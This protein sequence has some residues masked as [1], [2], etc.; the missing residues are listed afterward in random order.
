MRIFISGGT[1]FVGVHLADHFL[2][3]G[4]RVTAV[5]TSE[6]HPF[7]GRDSFEFISGDTVRPGPWQNAIQD[8]EAVVNLAGRTIFNYWTKKY[9]AQ[10]YDSRVITTRNIV[11]ALPEDRHIVFLST[12]AAGYYGNR[13]DETLDENSSP[14]NDFLS[15]LCQ[16]WEREALRAEEKGARVALMRFG[17]VLGKNGGALA[18][19][20]PA[21]RWFVGGPLGDGMQWF[22][23]IH[24]TDLISAVDFLIEH[25]SVDGPVNVCAPMPVRQKDFAKALGKAAHRPA[26]FRVPKFVLNL[27]MG[28]LGASLLA[29]QRS[30]PERLEN[31]GYAFH[32]RGIEAAL[33][34]LVN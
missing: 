21:F 32:F 6:R 16:D 9:K 15:T 18:K 31:K 10:M 24:M 25:R 17:V 27:I 1:G 34:D 12:S 22:P 7:Q 8:A 30:V 13:G 4:H 28:E 11:D 29:S 5:G 2:T 33:E 14:G 23:W 19:M 26:L 20:L 3:G